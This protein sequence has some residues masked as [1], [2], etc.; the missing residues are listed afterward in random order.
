MGRKR[1]HTAPARQARMSARIDFPAADGRQLKAFAR[2]VQVL[3]AWQPDEVAAVLRAA[4]TAAH[5]G[6]WAVGFVAYEAAPAF[7]PALRV[8]PPM[9]D[10]PLAC[11][12]LYEAAESEISAP[13]GGDDFRCEPWRMEIDRP[14]FDGD[15]H[16][17]HEDIR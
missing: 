13:P 11:F 4:E 15:I 9:P 6:L 12:A 5:R 17:L 14:R 1:R 7:D 8:G 10:L 16:Q 2:P 3:Q